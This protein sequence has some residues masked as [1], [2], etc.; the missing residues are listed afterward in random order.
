MKLIY[1]KKFS[2]IIAEYQIEAS[3]L[4]GR[5]F[6]RSSLKIA[7]VLTGKKNYRS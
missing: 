1:G 4:L 2:K 5:P 6:S 7:D 3:S